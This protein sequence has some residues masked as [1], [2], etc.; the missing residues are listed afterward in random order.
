MGANAVLYAIHGLCIST[1]CY[2]TYKTCN[3]NKIRLTSLR[4][5]LSDMCIVTPILQESGED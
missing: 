5:S 4:L 1:P 2:V 3:L